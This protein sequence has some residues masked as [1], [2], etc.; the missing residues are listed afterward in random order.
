MFFRIASSSSVNLFSDPAPTAVVATRPSSN[1]IHFFAS[2]TNFV[3]F[4]TFACNGGVPVDFL[5]SPTARHG[6]NILFGVF[7]GGL[8]PLRADDIVPSTVSY[9]LRLSSENVRTTDN[10][11]DGEYRYCASYRKTDFA[12]LASKSCLKTIFFFS[13]TPLSLFRLDNESFLKLECR[14]TTLATAVFL[15]KRSD[16]DV[17]PIR[18]ETSLRNYFY[19]FSSCTHR[20]KSHGENTLSMNGTCKVGPPYFR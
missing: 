7:D 1:S 12:E 18:I 20:E 15:A 14:F 6:V 5:L 2:P 3:F 17:G 19:D 9:I 8:G 11:V 10:R 13:K 4:K 16:F